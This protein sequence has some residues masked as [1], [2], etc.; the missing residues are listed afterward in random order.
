VPLSV[1]MLTLLRGCDRF[2]LGIVGLV[3]CAVSIWLTA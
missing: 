1:K 3:A 2:H